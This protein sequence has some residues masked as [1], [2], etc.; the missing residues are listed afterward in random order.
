MFYKLRNISNFTWF[1]TNTKSILKTP[2]VKCDPFS[3]IVC[4]SQVCHRDIF[5]Y[6]LAIKSFTRFV[7]PQKVYILDDL[8][9]TKKDKIL[10]YEHIEQVEIIPITNI[11]N[12][13]CPIG[14][15]WERLLFISDCVKKN[16]VIQLDSDTLTL[17]NVPEIINSVKENQSFMLGTLGGHKIQPM[18]EICQNVKSSNSNHVQIIAEKNF[19]FLANYEQLKYVRGCAAFTG[20]GKKS[21]SRLQVEQFSRRMEEIIGTAWSNWGSEQVTSNYIIANSQSAIVLPYPKYAGFRPEKDLKESSF[22]HFMGTYRFKKG[23]YIKLAK[24]VVEKL[25]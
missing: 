11:A 17:N 23:V 19:D 25:K 12:K 7:S 9:L 18:K 22:L 1:N 16:Y 4:V 13:K 24:D 20:F 5:M 3:S 8:S 21:F 2:V 14:A 6:L 15:C 10:I